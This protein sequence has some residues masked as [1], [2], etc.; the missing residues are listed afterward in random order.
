MKNIFSIRTNNIN[1]IFQG[2]TLHKGR[3][4]KRK[5]TD[6]FSVVKEPTENSSF[7]IDR[8]AS[9]LDLANENTQ[10]QTRSLRKQ[11]KSSTL[12][13]KPRKL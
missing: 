7:V 2:Q 8:K 3:T 13:K 9:K 6:E 12:L 5:I 11:T 1:C 10:K 4:Q